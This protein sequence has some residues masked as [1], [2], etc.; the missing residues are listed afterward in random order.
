ME[1]VRTNRNA[2]RAVSTVV[3]GGMLVTG[4]GLGGEGTRD[5]GKAH[6]T[7]TSDTG[8]P[9]TYVKVGRVSLDGK[10]CA[11]SPSDPQPPV[12]VNQD[13]T[14]RAQLDGRCAK[15]VGENYV[16]VYT[17]PAQDPSDVNKFRAYGPQDMKV[18]CLEHGQIIT[19]ANGVSSDIWLHVQ[20]QDQQHQDQTGY[21]PEFA[22]GYDSIGVP[23]CG[24]N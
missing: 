15:P 16:G 12:R 8:R 9:T 5:E 1:R 19:D 18:D 17:R 6:E 22:T 11:W 4:C 10:M 14:L 2:R 20:A 24:G 23:E 3:L 7:A 13:G 21:A